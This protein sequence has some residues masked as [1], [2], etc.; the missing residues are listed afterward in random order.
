MRPSVGTD[1]GSSRED[2]PPEEQADRDHEQVLDVEEPRVAERDVV[3]AA[4]VDD[5]PA[6][7]PDRQR[8]GRPRHERER[9][10]AP[11]GDR[12]AHGRREPEDE[13]RRRPVGDDHVLQQVEEH[14]VVD[15]DR[16]ERRVQRSHDEDDAGRERRR[17]P[18]AGPLAAPRAAVGDQRHDA[19][20]DEQRLERERRG[21][22]HQTT[23]WCVAGT[24]SLTRCSRREARSN[25]TNA[26]PR[27]AICSTII[28]T[29]ATFWSV[30]GDRP[31]SRTGWST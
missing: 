17:V 14:E 19:E 21:G 22:S 2:G 9:P 30:S 25:S 12:T 4:E 28:T 6:D 27:V 8:D 18:D 20:D 13:E 23:G 10:A 3:D 1:S 11:G 24:S 26:R 16:L 5:V 7:E 29:P 31:R 15:R